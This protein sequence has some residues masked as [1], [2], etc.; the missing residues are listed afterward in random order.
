[1]VTHLGD[2]VDELLA[3]D[4]HGC[5]DL[6]LEALVVGLQ[7]E[8]ARLAAVQ[9]QATAEWDARRLWA[10][11]GSKSATGRLARECR[12]SA[13]SANADLRRARRLRTM[14]HVAAALAAGALSVDVVDLLV[15]AN[16]P[17]IE[18][19]FAHYEEALVCE[20]KGSRYRDAKRI[21]VT[22]LDR[23]DSAASDRRKRRLIDGRHCSAV[24]TLNDTVDVRA[25]L[26]PIAGTEFKSE[27]DRLEQQLCPTAPWSLPR[28]C[29]P[30]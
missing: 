23:M 13:R 18:H 11:N 15:W 6:E 5:S 16:Q 20:C 19:L 3:R 12:V 8:R 25:L 4:V 14:P 27:L 28:R 2:A 10:R 29:S 7:R 17:G 24:R 1:M 30:C 26:D 9:A 22:W 21:V